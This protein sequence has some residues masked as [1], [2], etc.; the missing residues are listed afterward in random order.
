MSN[1][2]DQHWYH[3]LIMDIYSR[4][5]IAW[6][7]HDAESGELAKQLLE[8]AL[9]R[10]GCWH[11]SP[12]LHSDN[13]APMKPYS[14]KARLTELE[15]LMSYSRPRVSNDNPYSE[16]LFRTVK[17]C[18]AWPT[19]GFA[20]LS[21][22][23]DCMLTFERAYN[24]QHLHSGIRYVTPADRHQG[25]EQERLEHR[26]AVYKR[27]KRRHPQLW[28]GN[29]QTGRYLVWC[30]ST[31]EKCTKSSAINRLLKGSY[32]DNWVESHR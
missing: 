10:E 21:A 5:I 3:Y 12:V 17:Y 31:L 9:L 27:A 8:R 30:H 22:V 7:I 28:S 2:E 1:T 6:E 32:L 23:R 16:A 4:K 19:K 25:V 15:M 24:E 13:G 26:K 29:T 20:S 14:L 18:P 11:Q